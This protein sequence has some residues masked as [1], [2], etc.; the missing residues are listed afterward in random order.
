M[1]FLKPYLA[2]NCEISLCWALADGMARAA[3]KEIAMH[4]SASRNARALRRRTEAPGDVSACLMRAV[5]RQLGLG[6][7]R[8]LFCGNSEIVLDQLRGVVRQPRG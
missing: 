8:H 4:G 3:T 2:N 7:A 6:H 5:D 1:F